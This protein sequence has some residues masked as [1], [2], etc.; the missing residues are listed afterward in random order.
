MAEDSRVRK[1]SSNFMKPLSALRL[2]ASVT[3]A[4]GVVFFFNG[5]TSPKQSAHGA[6]GI[7]PLSIEELFKKADQNG[8]GKVSRQEF[9]DLLITEAFGIYDP[10]GRGYV[11]LDEYVAGG[12][13]AEDFRKIAKPGSDRFTLADAKSSKMVRDRMSTPFDGADVDG[14]GFLTWKE[15]EAYRKL[16]AP[17]TRGS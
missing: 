3:L 1:P 8:D 17:Y 12:G 10:K 16:A 4:A 7:N 13:T 11:T 14:T 9:S 2:L 6:Y 5:C 15:F